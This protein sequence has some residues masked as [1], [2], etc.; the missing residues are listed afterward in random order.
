MVLKV[1]AYKMI[2]LSSYTSTFQKL[3]KWIKYCMD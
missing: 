3:K 2:F 1:N